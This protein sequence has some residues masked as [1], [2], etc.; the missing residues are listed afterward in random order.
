MIPYIKDEEELERELSDA[1]DKI[2]VVCFTTKV[3]GGDANTTMV[4]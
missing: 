3:G 1:K 4:E 2:V